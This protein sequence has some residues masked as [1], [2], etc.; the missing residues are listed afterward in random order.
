VQ[1]EE[2]LKEQYKSRSTEDGTLKSGEGS[3]KSGEGST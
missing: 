3:L 1:V 2:F